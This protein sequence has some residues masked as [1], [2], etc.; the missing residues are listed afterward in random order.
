MMSYAYSPVAS[1][2]AVVLSPSSPADVRMFFRAAQ[3]V[4]QEETATAGVVAPGFAATELKY[5]VCE[6]SGVVSGENI[7]QEMTL[8]GNGAD[9]SFWVF[10]GHWFKTAQHAESFCGMLAYFAFPFP[11]GRVAY[12]ECVFKAYHNFK[13]HDGKVVHELG[14]VTIEP[15]R[16]RVTKKR[17]RRPVFYGSKKQRRDRSSPLEVAAV[18][19]TAA[20]VNDV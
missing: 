6:S 8:R 14:G 11:K 10:E 15:P 12:Q 3:G 1:A 5:A 7:G 20:N 2:A 19:S 9:I 4:K 17:K 18:V 13:G 16:V